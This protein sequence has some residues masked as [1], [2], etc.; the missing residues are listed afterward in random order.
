VHIVIYATDAGV[1]SITAV[2]IL[3]ATAAISIVGRVIMGGVADRIGN[4]PA[5]IIGFGLALVAFL[6]LLIAKE[7]WMLYL[8]ALIFGLG[9]WAVVA[10]MSPLVSELFGLR[11]HG[12]ILGGVFL[13][14]SLGGAIGPVIAGYIF[15]I[16]GGYSQAFLVCATVSI[17]GLVLSVLLKPVRREGR[18]SELRRSA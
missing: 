9:G 1:S 6:W 17:I 15:D 13:G 16:S 10:M 3:S 7:L 4:R 18:A 14:A 11:S 5:C 8:F 12:V 2:T